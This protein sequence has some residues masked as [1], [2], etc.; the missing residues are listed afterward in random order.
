M[1]HSVN[2]HPPLAANDNPN[3]FHD[4]ATAY[5]ELHRLRRDLM[6]K[7]KTGYSADQWR[8]YSEVLQQ[9]EAALSLLRPY[10]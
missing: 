10:L 2:D 6:A 7:D 5:L 4:P 8:R 9:L 3:P 1:D